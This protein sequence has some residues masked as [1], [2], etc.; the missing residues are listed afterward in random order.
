MK[1]YM[2]NGT[3]EL[4]KE[5]KTGDIVLIILFIT[6]SVFSHAFINNLSRNSDIIIKY[7]GEI[8]GKYPYDFNSKIE[9]DSGIIAE[10]RNGE[11]RMIK[12]NCKNKICIEQ[13][14]STLT[15]IICVPNEIIIMRKEI[16][17]EYEFITK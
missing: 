9:I 11:F 1:K 17:K 15:P 8:F 13:G 3:K 7:Q 16:N 6:I 4:L 2:V 5:L 14:W 10:I 12:S